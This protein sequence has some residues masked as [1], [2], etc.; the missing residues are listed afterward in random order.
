MFLQQVEIANFRGIKNLRIVFDDVT[1]LIGEN[2]TGKTTILD[3]LQLC[4]SKSLTRKGGI[5]TEYDYHLPNKDSQ[6]SDAEPIE[7]SFRF[8]EKKEDEWPD[9]VIQMLSEAIQVDEDG[10]QSL[11]FRVTSRFDELLNDFTTVWDFLDSSGHPLPKAKNPRNVFQ[12]QQL[13]PVFYLAALRD[14]VQEFRPRSQFWGPFVRTM[15][16]ESGLREELEKDLS[17]LNKRILDAHRSFDSIKE[18]LKN[19]TKLMP[20][21]NEESV[22]IEALPGKVFDML[23]RTQVML[24]SKTGARLPIG[25]HGEGTQSLA[26]ICLFDAFLQSRLEEGYDKHTAPILALEEPESHLHP[27]AIRSVAGMLQK[28][29]GQKVFATH[30]GDLVAGVPLTSLRRL[31]R[32]DGIITIHQIQ[33]GV[34]TADDLN[35]LDYHLRLTRGN[36][37]FSHCW[38]LVEGEADHVVFNECARINGHD[39]SSE[40]VCCVEFSTASVEQFIKLADQLG[41]DWIVVADNDPQG[42]QYLQT[43]SAHLNGRPQ[44]QHLHKLNHGDMETFMCMEGYGALFKANISPQ[45]QINITEKSGTPKY[46]KQVIDARQRSFTKPKAMIAICKK[47]EENGPSGVPEQI[48]QIV[49]IALQ[50]AK[51]SKWHQN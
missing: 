32:K 42:E 40:G 50:L 35:K 23:S 51:E 17:E 20:L 43:A 6:P 27:S 29:K 22:I 34:L 26:V 14:A 44:G 28:L 25:R 10:R 39:L 49:D 33:D 24:T 8:A 12:L 7:I 1:V 16:I 45:K 9:E 5:F 13:A 30:S 2:N 31:R 47:I 48:V 37:L 4:L 11:T 3:A 15:K 19:T 18:R 38:I 41:I 36:L 21:G 46:W